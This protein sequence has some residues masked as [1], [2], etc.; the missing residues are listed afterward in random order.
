MTIPDKAYNVFEVI[1]DVLK[2]WDIYKLIKK[3]MNKYPGIQKYKLP[4]HIVE[5]ID[6]RFEYLSKK[7]C[8][9]LELK[10]F[11]NKSYKQISKSLGIS[12]RSV[13]NWR[14]RILLKIAKRGGLI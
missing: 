11:N 4:V 13:A 9:Y 7:E 6:D 2:Y 8:K 5:C 12:I 14:I 3:D 10:Y 1:E